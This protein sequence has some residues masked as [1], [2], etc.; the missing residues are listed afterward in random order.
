MTH[1]SEQVTALLHSGVTL[2]QERRHDEALAMFEALLGLVP[3]HAE[4]WLRHGVSLQ[5]LGR[6]DEALGS[7]DRALAADPGYAAAWN[8]RGGLLNYLGS[9][10]E[11]A[12]CY[13]Q[14]IA[15]GGD[16]E[17]NGYFLA[18]LR[19][20][21]MPPAAPREY[22]R[23][24]FDDHADS[25]DEHLLGRLNY[26]APERLV[27]TL[28]ALRS[29]MRFRRAL[30]LGCGTGLCGALLRPLADALDGVDLSARML[31]KARERGV[32]EHLVHTEIGEHLH[33]TTQ[34]YDLVISAD[35]FIY[36]GALAHAFEGARR[37]LD[38]GGIF[39]FSVEAAAG[40]ADF[41]LRPTQRYAHS[42]RYL[43][44][45]AAEHR[46]EVLTLTRQSL[47]EDRRGGSIEGHYVHLRA[48]SV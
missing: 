23:Q 16:P 43:R 41:E 48:V 19:G 29:S 46:F 26:R 35:V 40:S 42:E 22:V 25:F 33:A 13:E 37:V 3:E 2:Q 36:I 18:S 17:L 24:V 31:D 10:E 27:E 12:Y 39:C 45:L 9:R 11:T 15:H 32:Y 44:A 7:Y 5:G 30:D 20:G 38:P 1:A 4:A 21:P 8:R 47:R 28:K 14:A 6:H 34:R